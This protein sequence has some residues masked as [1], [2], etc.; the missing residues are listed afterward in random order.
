MVTRF[1]LIII[2]VLPLRAQI[3]KD[4]LWPTN[5]SNH[6]TSSF[7]E[8][9]PGHYHSAIDIKTWNKEGYP[10]YA[11]SDAFVYRIR[12][13]PFGYG[14]VI[15]LRLDDGNYAVYAHLQRFSD[16]LQKKVR[17]I[18]LA[19]KRYT[20]NWMPD[21]I[22]V[23]KGEILGYTGQTG[24][25]SPHLHFEIRDPYERPMN[26][27]LFYNNRI[28]DTKAPV[29]K[30]LLVIPMKSESRVNGSAKEQIFPL[31][32]SKNNTYI[33]Q[34]PIKTKGPVGLAITGYDQ[35]NGVH[36]KFAFYNTILKVNDKPIFHQQYN[37]FDFAITNQVDIEIFYPQ[38][39]KNNKVY[40]KLY[41]EP[42]N[43]LPFYDRSL[44]NGI[45]TQ[46]D[47][48][49]NF[50]IEVND[51]AGNISRIIGKIEMK[52]TNSFKIQILNRNNNSLFLYLQTPYNLKGLDFYSSTDNQLWQPVSQFEILNR[53]LKPDFQQFLVKLILPDTLQHYVK[54]D[55]GSYNDAFSLYSSIINSKQKQNI[56]LE[57]SN[58]GESVLLDFNPVQTETGLKLTLNNNLQTSTIIPEIINNRFEYVIPGTYFTKYPLRVTLS[59]YKT[60]YI[61]TLLKVQK[62]IPE[63]Y[64]R[65]EFLDGSV[66]I[67]SRPQSVYDTLLFDVTKENSAKSDYG[68]PV[69]KSVYHF[70]SAYQALKGGVEMVIK[71]DSLQINTSHIG[72]YTTDRKRKLE[73][74]ESR[75]DTVE[76]TIT[77][78]LQAFGMYF[79]AA[80]TIRPQ[81]RILNLS[82]NQTLKSIDEIKFMAKDEQSGIGED[83]NINISIDNQFVLPE[84]DPERDLITGHPHWQV[85]P[86]MHEI[87]VDVKDMA[88]N[89]TIQKL[90]IIV[91]D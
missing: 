35:A 84:W 54:T 28:K 85:K 18:Q 1:L 51:F 72:I 42:Y 26:P 33:I 83:L 74:I 25:G 71:M 68:I 22:R 36:N 44:G 20:L 78:K 29:L 62:M 40:H 76:N 47:S 87:L 69:L 80:D 10:I 11:I 15:Y 90:S 39:V 41:I 45:I 59:D 9:R 82:N 17:A 52:N 77:G 32:Y 38:K 88:G 14:K 60:V 55:I 73:L 21:S 67:I 24:I 65:L 91:E 63:N 6:L 7:C 43:Q 89:Q 57:M 61:D 50:Q 56:K 30:A 31:K 34:Q 27:L 79:I 8:Y 46:N 64:Q 70:N 53:E 58:L 3:K 37:V 49:N 16:K 5:A 48:I 23:K 2:L 81:L 75:I 66:Q 13:S 12:V 19:N 4:Y 86:G